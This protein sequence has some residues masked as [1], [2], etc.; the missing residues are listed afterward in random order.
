MRLLLLYLRL[1]RLLLG[2]LRLPKLRLRRLLLLQLWMLLLLY[3]RLRRLLR[4]RLRLSKLRLRR[5][6]LLQLWMLL[7]LYQRLR[8]LLRWR[9]RLSKLRLRR[10]LLLQLWMLLLLYQRLR[11]LLLRRL[12]LSKLWLSLLLPRWQLL[13]RLLSWRDG[14]PERPPRLRSDITV[15]R[16]ARRS[17]RLLGNYLSLHNRS[18]RFDCRDGGGAH[19]AF[20]HRRHRNVA[21]NLRPLHLLR[22]NSN[23][24][25]RHGSRV[26][27]RVVRDRGDRI[28][29]SLVYVSN[30]V[31]IHVV[32]NIRDIND[33]HRCI[34]YVHVLHVTHTGA[35]RRNVHFTRAKREPRHASPST[36]ERHGRAESRSA[37][38]DDQ[39]RR[40][41]GAHN[42]RTRNP[43]PTSADFRPAPVVKWSKAPRFVFDPGP[44]PGRN[45]NPMSVAVRRPSG[46]DASR[47][48]DVSVIGHVSPLA[49]VVEVVVADYVT[50]D[51]AGGF[52]TLFAVVAG[53]AP[54][55]KIVETPGLPAVVG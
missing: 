28:D 4:R 53:A 12:C 3:H 24:G 50:G 13:L 51:V 44:S 5:L 32:V 20:L 8:R 2:G 36:A 10:L 29:I 7:L 52:G 41:H 15:E 55:V 54:V 14:R 16:G 17:R 25:S 9:L 22:I 45:P 21:L 11:R 43:A 37:D 26:H 42:H 31:D 1:R 35:I 19:Y 38:E 23:V 34:R 46:S 47:K 40:I 49:V 30:L 6:L 33:V 48:P 39:G 27:E 18:R